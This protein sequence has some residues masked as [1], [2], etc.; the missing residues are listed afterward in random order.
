[1]VRSDSFEWYELGFAPPNCVP[2]FFFFGLG[3]GEMVVVAPT[4]NCAH[5]LHYK[6]VTT[7]MCALIDV[8]EYD[9]LKTSD[10]IGFLLYLTTS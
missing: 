8:T 7:A 5:Y 2:F 4:N 9:S 1:M 10:S 6:L 3:C